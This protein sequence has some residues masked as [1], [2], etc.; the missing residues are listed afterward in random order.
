MKGGLIAMV[1]H[2]EADYI[3]N[4]AQV[5]AF[6]GNIG[7]VAD[8]TAGEFVR[9][10]CTNAHV[11]RIDSAADASIRLEQRTIDMFIHDI[12]SI[13]W[14]VASNESD[15][16]PVLDPLNQESFGWGIRRGND[17]FLAQVNQAIAKWKADGSLEAAI[18]EWIPYYS[19][20]K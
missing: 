10:T 8:T 15:L 16:V 7:V 20:M 9:S 3:T 5:K 12:P 2:S 4:A 14:Q 18:L 19:K 11:V 13:L 6:S 1:R 17:E